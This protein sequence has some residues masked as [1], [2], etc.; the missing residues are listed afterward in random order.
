MSETATTTPPATSAST[1]APATLDAT[2]Q[3]AADAI[4]AKAAT[5]TTTTEPAKAAETATTQT[6]ADV[7]YALALPKDAVIEASAVER[8][9]SFAKEHKLAPD[10]AQ[11][12]LDLAAAE[13]KADRD[14]QNEVAAESF[15][16]MATK[17]WVDDLKAD[18]DFGG[19]KYLVTVEEVKRAADRFL[20]PEDRETLNV[21]GWG[22]H[23]MLC[24]MFARIG[25][26]MGNDK[27]V[28]GNSGSGDGEVRLADRMFTTK[29]V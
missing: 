19:E 12:A 3:A 29:P 24:K 8:L 1:P 21:T 14:K 4:A 27:L 15:K 11:K 5:T 2:A 22:N 25:R 28:N 13:V 18:K 16:T 23:P 26:A 7:A 6:P 17:Q 9:T 20:T 10:V